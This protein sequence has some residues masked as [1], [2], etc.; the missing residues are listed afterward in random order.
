MMALARLAELSREFLEPLIEGEGIACHFTRG[1]SCCC[2]PDAD[3]FAKARLD[4]EYQAT[5]GLHQRALTAEQCVDHEPA[6]EA[7]VKRIAGGIW[8][9]N[10]A[11]ADCGEFCAQLAQRIAHRGGDSHSNRARSLRCRRRRGARV[12]ASDASAPNGSAPLR[13]DAY[14]LAAGAIWRAGRNGRDQAADLRGKRLLDHG[15][16]ASTLRCRGSDH[17]CTAQGRLCHRSVIACASPDSP[18]SARIADSIPP[19]RVSALLDAAREVLGYH[20]VDGD[21]GQ[22]A[23]LRPATPSG[24]PII[25]RTPIA[26]LVSERRP[27]RAGLDTCRR[28]RAPCLRCDRRRGPTSSD[29]PCRALAL[30]YRAYHRSMHA[31]IAA[32]CIAS[33]AAAIRSRWR[34]RV[35]GSPTAQGKRYLDAS[36]GAAVSCL[37]HGHPDVLAAMH[38][39][40]DELAYAHTSFFTTEVAE[41]LADALIA[42]APARHLARLPRHRADRKRSRPR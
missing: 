2:M 28:Q 34:V 19:A 17:R 18:K 3:W 4:A 12:V 42:A 1:G 8:T 11:V 20:S 7:T 41:E 31:R 30:A 36:G 38:A 32:F 5:R 6:L 15:Q 26:T 24:R 33:C 40:I 27:R 35:A 22:W 14:V 29:N 37:G 10:D 9:A 23:G 16:A 25:G 39:Q 21:F 13:A